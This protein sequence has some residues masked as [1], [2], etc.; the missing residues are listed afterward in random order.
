MMNVAAVGVHS[1]VYL[2]LGL[3][4]KR[5]QLPLLSFQNMTIQKELL[6]LARVSVLES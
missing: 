3:S 2:T 5:A 6:E 1:Q 4:F